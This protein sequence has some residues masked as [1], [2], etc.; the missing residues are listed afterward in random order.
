M[1]QMPS[2]HSCQTS[3]SPSALRATGSFRCPKG[4]EARDARRAGARL[5]VAFWS[6]FKLAVRPSGVWLV[7]TP[8]DVQ[9]MPSLQSS[10]TSNSPSALRATGSFQ[11]VARRAGRRGTPEG[12]RAPPCYIQ[13]NL[14]TRRPPFGRLARFD[15][16]DIQVNLQTR[17]PPFGR[18]ARFDASPEGRGGARRP[19]GRRAPPY[20]TR[21]PPF[22]R[23]ACF[24]ARR[25]G[26]RARPKGR[27]AP[28]CCILGILVNLRI[29]SPSAL[30]AAGSFRP[31]STNR[32]GANEAPRSSSWPEGPGRTS[33]I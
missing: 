8:D 17:H 28:P 10:Q 32:N 9:Q 6:N 23:L 33:H 7:S 12:R 13:V 5:H 25:A 22:G 26:R 2:F 14:Q 20:E 16:D 19:K 29:N 31:D 30:R 21:H 18:L 1:Q 27:R 4:R 11:G 15:A 24:G 3:N